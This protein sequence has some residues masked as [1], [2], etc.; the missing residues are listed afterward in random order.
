MCV[1]IIYGYLYVPQHTAHRL[2]TVY[3]NLS[4]LYIL[5]TLYIP[6]PATYTLP[7]PHPYTIC[8]S[9][10]QL[11]Q[12]PLELLYEEEDRKVP[13]RQTRYTWQGTCECGGWEIS[14]RLV[15]EVFVCIYRHV[16]CSS[17]WIGVMC[18]VCRSY[19]V[20]RCILYSYTSYLTLIY[21]HIHLF[22]SVRGGGDAGC[23]LREE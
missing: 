17:I 12:E 9:H 21:I 7:P 15:C 4:S 6:S 22:R 5:T 19:A 3:I 11:H 2:H 18:T 10:G 20:L 1:Y 14:I 23:D 13:V 16:V 8:R